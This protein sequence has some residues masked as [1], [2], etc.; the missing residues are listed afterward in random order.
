[1]PQ[2]P[3]PASSTPGDKWQ[4]TGGRLVN[5]F[6]SEV[7]GAPASPIVW[8]RVAGL[9][10]VLENTAHSGC[11]GFVAVGNILLYVLSGQVYSV[12][13]SG[14]ALVSELRGPLAGTKPITV[15]QNIASTPNTVCVTENGAFNLFPAGAPSAF[16]DGDLPT[17]NSV[18]YIDGYMIFSTAGGQLWATG[19]NNVSVDTNSF[20]GLPEGSLLRVIEYG[21]EI[22]AFGPWGFRVYQ[23]TGRS[24]F[25]LEYSRVKRDIG[26]IG[27]HAIAGEQ[28]GWSDALI[29]AASDNRVYRMEGYTPVP[30]STPDVSRALESVTDRSALVASVYVAEGYS[31][32]TLT[33]PGQWTWEYNLQTGLWHERESYGRSD[34]RGR[35]SIRMFDK[36]IIG[37]AVTGDLLEAE[38]GYGY[39]RDDPLVYTL[40]S[41]ILSAFPNRVNA[42]RSSFRFTAGVGIESGADPIEKC[43]VVEI[44]WSLNGGATFGNPLVRD[45]GKEGDYDTLVTIGNT[46]LSS[47]KGL[48]YK[49]EVSDPVYVGFM[50]G[51]AETEVRSR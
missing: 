25:P 20:E 16:A 48:Q 19:L 23:N 51:D 29:Y 9:R 24:P 10:R 47:S 43:P 17:P 2:I 42:I 14:G 44:S 15:A 30:I 28:N 8:H 1:M 6:V 34:W 41:G 50:G 7:G 38:A 45:L 40:Y 21:D 27:T 37:D 32:W 49:L 22:F 39:E 35:H 33:S 12:V 3:F 46:G 4:E 26:L 11:R 31:Y 5:C 36:W 18:A 13:Q